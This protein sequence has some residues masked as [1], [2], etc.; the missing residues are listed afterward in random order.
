MKLISIAAISENYVIAAD[1][2][3]PWNI[4]EDMKRFKQLTTGHPVIMGRVT[5]ET[6]PEKFRPL[7]KRLNIVV[8]S[9]QQ[10]YPSGVVVVPSLEEALNQ[11]QQQQV[12]KMEGI[13]YEEAY[14]IGGQ[15][16]YFAAMSKVNK[17]EITHVHQKIIGSLNVRYFPRIQA[18]LW[19][20][21][22]REDKEGFSFVSYEKKGP[23]KPGSS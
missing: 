20:E 7:A 11:V 5:Y 8:S 23:W 3:I 4:P 9:K 19:Q 2:Q 17:L 6:I 1:G 12:P 22:Q 10:N 16:L 21:V 18:M 13:D 15:S 14:I